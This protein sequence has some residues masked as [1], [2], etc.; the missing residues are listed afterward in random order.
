[1]DVD[2][3]AAP[4]DKSAPDAVPDRSPHG[5]AFAVTPEK[6]KFVPR[7]RSVHSSPDRRQK[8][9]LGKIGEAAPE[10]ALEKCAQ[11]LGSGSI[12]HLSIAEE[13]PPRTP[14][15]VR[16]VDLFGKDESHESLT[17]TTPRT[18]QGQRPSASDSPPLPWDKLRSSVQS[19]SLGTSYR[20]G[21]R[22]NTQPRHGGTPVPEVVLL[23]APL[24]VLI[25]E[26]HAPAGSIV[27]SVDWSDDLPAFS[28]FPVSL[29][30]PSD[31]RSRRSNTPPS[32]TRP[33]RTTEPPIP[34][35]SSPLIRQPWAEQRQAAASRKSIPLMNLVEKM[36]AF[37]AVAVEV[38]PGLP[39]RASGEEDAA[40]QPERAASGESSDLCSTAPLLSGLVDERGAS[41]CLLYEAP[42]PPPPRQQDAAAEQKQVEPDASGAHLALGQSCIVEKI[43]H[44]FETPPHDDSEPAVRRILSEPC[45][46]PPRG[47]LEASSPLSTFENLPDDSDDVTKPTS[48]HQNTSDPR[49]EQQRSLF[50]DSNARIFERHAEDEASSLGRCPFGTDLSWGAVDEDCMQSEW[51]D[52]RYCADS[53]EEEDDLLEAPLDLDASEG[54]EQSMLSEELSEQQLDEMQHLAHVGGLCSPI[55]EEG[56]IDTGAGVWPLLQSEEETPDA[57]I[58]SYSASPADHHAECF[59]SPGLRREDSPRFHTPLAP[60]HEYEAY[61]VAM[62]PEYSPD[63]VSDGSACLPDSRDA[64]GLVTKLIFD[65]DY[66]S[67]DPSPNSLPSAEVAADQQFESAPAHRAV[68]HRDI[69]GFTE[70]MEFHAMPERCEQDAAEEEEEAS[71]GATSL[72]T[73]L[74]IPSIGRHGRTSCPALLADDD[75]DGEDPLDAVNLDLEDLDPTSGEVVVEQHFDDSDLASYFVSSLVEAMGDRTRIHSLIAEAESSFETYPDD[76]DDGN[77]N[78]MWL[79][80]YTAA[81]D[82]WDCGEDPPSIE[83]CDLA[84]KLLRKM[85]HHATVEEARDFHETLLTFPVGSA[86]ARLFEARAWLEEQHGN[87]QAAREMLSR[88]LRA[89]AK[90][91]NL[92]SRAL[93]RLERQL[94]QRAR[95]SFNSTTPATPPPLT[96]CSPGLRSMASPGFHASLLVTP[97]FKRPGDPSCWRRA[98][99]EHSSA[100]MC[101]AFESLQRQVQSL[102]VQVHRLS[103][104]APPAHHSDGSL[105]GGR[106][107]HVSENSTQTDVAVPQEIRNT[108]AANRRAPVA[109]AAWMLSFMWRMFRVTAA[110]ASAI[111]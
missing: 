53:E 31:K 75:N 85:A 70:P 103:S 95:S 51:P 62:T 106:R 83:L 44:A 63:Q 43:A 58:S 33:R 82:S 69:V 60:V 76:E 4:L 7:P 97:D 12:S 78:K 105:S 14:H 66:A 88:G 73:R 46:N 22:R 15:S 6:L 87:E 68:W 93:A 67:L 3:L 49:C 2:L 80:I 19:R 84:V 21:R 11:S 55:P 23:N 9:G 29:D 92:L 52:E 20:S 17:P 54:G 77:L 45:R 37:P 100:E 10:E 32:D 36:S 89:R 38:E 96:S 16:P 64:D 26:D 94:R 90:P 50:D 59:L 91:E 65:D 102:Q 108:A 111:E 72:T 57:P 40:D 86:D 71:P 47:L 42:P 81:I 110:R 34:W 79:R 13:Q 61:E 28:Q 104:D 101:S 1:M 41:P 98:V 56:P 35:S 25:K 24:Q 107:I 99:D 39:R 30:S 74:L 5:A 27:D 48:L 109:A 18:Q 8:R